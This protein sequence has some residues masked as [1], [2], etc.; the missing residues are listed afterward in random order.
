LAA[1]T[2]SS[3]R[4]AA[5]AFVAGLLA[6]ATLPVAIAATRWSGRY[7]LVHAAF[8]IPLALLLSVLAI[9]FA[10]RARA[11]VQRTLGRAGGER[12]LRWGRAL[13]VLGL[14]LSLTAAGSV[15]VYGILSY[16]AER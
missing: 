1:R 11:H 12:L 14:L 16:V 7:E 8:A 5:A 2:R 15:A 6:V 3:N 9:R 10:R 4:S 13:G